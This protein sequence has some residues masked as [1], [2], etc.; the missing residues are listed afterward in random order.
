[1]SV[2]R[3]GRAGKKYDLLV[4]RSAN[5]LVKGTE[6][7]IFIRGNQKKIGADGALEVNCAGAALRRE[8][9]GDSLGVLIDRLGRAFHFPARWQS[10]SNIV[11]GEMREVVINGVGASGMFEEMLF[12]VGKETRRKE[13]TFASGAQP[14]G[15][16]DFKFGDQGG[17]G[18]D[19]LRSIL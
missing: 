12:V 9:V 4:I 8:G 14:A 13:G 1:M 18:A 11:G 5:Y 16:F 3:Q 17:L 10:D 7:G 6:D 15:D 2:G 19:P